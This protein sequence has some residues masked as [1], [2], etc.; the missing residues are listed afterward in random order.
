MEQVDAHELVEQ[1]GVGTLA[2]VGVVGVADLRQQA[3]HGVDRDRVTRASSAS[4]ETSIASVVLPVPTSPMNQ[5]PRPAAR[6]LVEVS[7]EAA[8]GPDHVRAQLGDRRAVE[9]DPSVLA[10]DHRRDAG[11]PRPAHARRA[12]LAGDR[13]TLVVEHEAVAAA[14]RALPVLRPAR[15]K[16]VAHSSRTPAASPGDLLDRR[17]RSACAMFANFGYRG[18]NDS[19]TSPDRAVAVLGDVDLGDPLASRSR[20]CS[21]RRGR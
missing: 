9:R 11:G 21:T 3:R 4:F 10:R 1:L 13:L 19:S 5:S 15:A 2:P 17:A 6:L 12:A 7:H 16:R 14:V 8:H 20:G 18:R